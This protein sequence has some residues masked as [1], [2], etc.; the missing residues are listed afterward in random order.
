MISHTNESD[1]KKTSKLATA[2][3]LGF[4]RFDVPMCDGTIKKVII[5]TFVLLVCIGTY[6][7]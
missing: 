7:S 3:E 4:N 5:Y 2:R 1:I 6:F